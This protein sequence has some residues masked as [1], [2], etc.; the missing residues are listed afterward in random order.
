MI[1]SYVVTAG[2]FAGIRFP[3]SHFID[4]EENRLLL[5][6]IVAA[7]S[8]IVYLFSWLTCPKMVSHKDM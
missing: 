2:A 4:M 6:G 8:V 3:L 1:L 7:F 5:Y